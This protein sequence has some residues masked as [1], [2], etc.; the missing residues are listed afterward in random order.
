MLIDIIIALL[1]SIAIFL[2]IISFRKNTPSFEK[3]QKHNE[4]FSIS[5][6]DANGPTKDCTG[7]SQACAHM[8][9]P[10]PPGYEAPGKTG[11]IEVTGICGLVKLMNSGLVTDEQD[12]ELHLELDKE[13]QDVN[14]LN[15]PN[16][17]AMVVELMVINGFFIQNWSMDD[18]KKHIKCYMD[19]ADLG[20]CL[21]LSDW[22]IFADYFM[23]ILTTV[24]TLGQ[25]TYTP[26]EA[27][28]PQDVIKKQGLGGVLSCAESHDSDCGDECICCHDSFNPNSNSA[29]IYSIC[30]HFWASDFTNA[31]AV[32]GGPNDPS[33]I[34]WANQLSDSH[35]ATI[36]FHAVVMDTLPN[37]E[38]NSPNMPNQVDTKNPIM[39]YNNKEFTIQL[40]S[41]LVGKRVYVQGSYVTDMDH[42][43][44]PTDLKRPMQ[45]E[46]HPPSGWAFAWTEG[47]G[48]VVR[49]PL[50]TK[51]T[52]LANDCTPRGYAQGSQI[53]DYLLASSKI[54]WR[55]SGFTNSS[56]HHC[57]D[58]TICGQWTEKY[59]KSRW[60]L[61]LPFLVYDWF[62]RNVTV[63][64]GV[65]QLKDES[66]LTK[67][68][69]R[70]SRKYC[71]LQMNDDGMS[72]C[73][74]GWNYKKINSYVWQ[75]YMSNYNNFPKMANNNSYYYSKG[76]DS[77]KELPY[78][79]FDNQNWM[80]MQ[81]DFT[82]TDTDLLSGKLFP[83]DSRF[84][85]GLPVFMVEIKTYMPDAFGSMVTLDYSIELLGMKTYKRPPSTTNQVR[86]IP[87]PPS[88]NNDGDCSDSGYP[89]IN[90][91]CQPCN[92]KKLN[93][94]CPQDTYCSDNGTCVPRAIS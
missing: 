47:G 61:G 43:C 48:N 62:R 10:I 40:K 71:P 1:I 82:V 57:C 14:N 74:R 42:G 39:P 21:G 88:C 85:T 34:D 79:L 80:D 9:R 24:L 25:K 67:F 19:E 26:Y 93:Y 77:L 35:Q 27:P 92:N 45:R 63:T 16:K 72:G 81:E 18:L 51:M 23:G 22:D 60:E 50:N 37:A 2:L 52:V 49:F 11:N 90:G 28:D 17:K 41:L 46:I 4:T 54:H 36:Q 69:F 38:G 70:I 65:G 91:F 58:G 12:L 53:T 8:T 55:I 86:Y 76:L 59:P 64:D 94:T 5:C 15:T 66:K 73:R 32:V 44:S 13:I 20:S 56:L 78:L 75:D 87:P 68:K 7:C 3:K 6:A 29:L 30:N 31:I 83:I 33:Y 84:K 89:C